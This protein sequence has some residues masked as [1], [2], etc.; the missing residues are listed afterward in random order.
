[1]CKLRLL[2]G[3]ADG[4]DDLAQAEVVEVAFSQQPLVACSW[5]KST[6]VVTIS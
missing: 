2:R 6:S 4:H 5:K 1:M 3:A